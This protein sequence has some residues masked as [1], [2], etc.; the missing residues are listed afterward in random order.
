MPIES[1]ADESIPPGD[2]SALARQYIERFGL[3]ALYVADLDAIERSEPQ[4]A[5]IRNTA[6]LGVP[7]WLDAGLT[8]SED[9]RHG[10][11]SGASRLIV[12]LETLSS[13]QE[14]ESIVNDVGHQQVVF[15]LDLRDGQPVAAASDLTMKRP[16]DLVAR[17]VDAG[18]AA[19]IVLDLARVGAGCGLDLPLVSRLRSA[20]R[21]VPLYAGGGVRSLDD[22]LQAERVGCDGVLIAS[23]LLDGHITEQD[24]KS[25]L[26]TRAF[27]P[28]PLT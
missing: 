21:S 13:F 11:A 14:F 15:S 27:D 24:L 19:V 16:E 25:T 18:I 4:H 10:L 12:G 8:S 23:A 7:V 22:L 9:A 6:S 17:A 20:S 3:S 1:V 26:L 28:C 5:V 2:V